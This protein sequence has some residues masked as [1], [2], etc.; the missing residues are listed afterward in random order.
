MAHPLSGRERYQGVPRVTVVE[1]HRA[2]LV[3]TVRSLAVP[4]D[5]QAPILNDWNRRVGVVA[6][7]FSARRESALLGRG[8]APVFPTYDLVAH[9]FELKT[10]IAFH[11]GLLPGSVPDIGLDY[12][13]FRELVYVDV[14]IS[15]F[16]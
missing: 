10:V 16:T 13:S 4:V 7:L 9:H 2:R 8:P 15:R 14:S 12:N 11:F 1:R 5:L 3:A 6:G